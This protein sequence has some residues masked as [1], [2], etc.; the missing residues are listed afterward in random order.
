MATPGAAAA[1]G[2]I[3][4][5][6]ARAATIRG[7]RRCGTVTA[8]TGMFAAEPDRS[9]RAPAMTIHLWQSWPR[10]SHQFIEEVVEVRCALHQ[11]PE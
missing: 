9:L 8:R 7:S 5:R 2:V 4:R 10:T 3:D 11:K 1:I 6:S